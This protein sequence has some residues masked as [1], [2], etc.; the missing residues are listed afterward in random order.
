MPVFIVFTWYNDDY[1]KSLQKKVEN[2]FTNEDSA[3]KLVSKLITQR[4][5]RDID[6][7]NDKIEEIERRGVRDPKTKKISHI[8]PE[9]LKRRGQKELASVD[10][11]TKYLENI[12]EIPFYEEHKLYK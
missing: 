6:E 1:R 3:A 10:A 2:V 8:V 11:Y 5:L 4:Y 7:T 12:S 9:Y